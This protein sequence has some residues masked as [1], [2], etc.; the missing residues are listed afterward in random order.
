MARR[1]HP[2]EVGVYVQ[3]EGA[4][5]FR[6][7]RLRAML[8]QAAHRMLGH[9]FVACPLLLEYPI[10]V[11]IGRTQGIP[12]NPVAQGPV[13]N[14]PA[15]GATG[16]CVMFTLAEYLNVSPSRWPRL[17]MPG[18]PKFSLPGFCFA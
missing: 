15:E 11:L 5:A 3:Q 7:H 8:L 14:E 17:P 2:G 12:V 10:A 9:L 4:E 18:V 16:T 13:R 1:R 6:D